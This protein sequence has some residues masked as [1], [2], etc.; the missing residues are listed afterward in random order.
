MNCPLPL[1]NLSPALAS[2][3]HPLCPPWAYH[4]PYNVYCP[5]FSHGTCHQL[6]KKKK[7]L[8]KTNQNPLNLIYIIL[9]PLQSDCIEI[10]NKQRQ[11]FWRL[12]SIWL[13]SMFIPPLVA[14]FDLVV[15]SVNS[16]LRVTDWLTDSLT[17][18]PLERLVM[19]RRKKR[20]HVF[21]FSLSGF[22]MVQI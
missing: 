14:L 10:V 15:T 16:V 3:D 4:W 8:Q 20:F 12:F 22:L 1:F 17:L 18:P 6:K 9:W 21:E 19:L 2:W 13:K 7:D 5:L 11:H